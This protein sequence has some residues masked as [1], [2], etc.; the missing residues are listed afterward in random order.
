VYVIGGRSVAQIVKRPGAGEFRAHTHRGGTF[1][2]AD[3]DAAAADL[4]G[5]TVAL[6]SGRFGVDLPYARVDVLWLDG[7]WVVSEL[8]LI[9]PGLNFHLDSAIATAYV[10]AMLDALDAREVQP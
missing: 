4:A 8:E 9:E 3:L 10:D 2:R 6:V 5:S 1:E 7:R